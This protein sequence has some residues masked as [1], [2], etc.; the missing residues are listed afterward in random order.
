MKNPQNKQKIAQ[1]HRK[2]T[3]VP[4]VRESA[5]VAPVRESA[6]VAPVRVWARV[7]EIKIHRWHLCKKN[8]LIY[9]SSD[10]IKKFTPSLP[11]NGKDELSNC[12]TN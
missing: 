12:R 11:R 1:P 6:Q 8:N 10:I 5:Q 3:Q 2:N 9:I 4:P 7:C